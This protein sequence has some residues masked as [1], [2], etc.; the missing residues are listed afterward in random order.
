[1][2]NIHLR[3]TFYYKNN[4][5][6]PIRAGGVIIY[7]KNNNETEVLLIKKIKNDLENYEDIG[8]KTSYEDT[9]ILDTVSREVSE[10]TN[11]IINKNIIK[12]QINQ[13]KYKSIYNI[14]SKYILYFIKANSYERLLE[15]ENFGNL[16]IYDKIERTIV[17]VNVNEIINKEI[18]IHPRLILEDLINNIITL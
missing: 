6:K 9:S 12:K 5:N 8:G 4:K 10:E 2:D 3:P 17:W 7:R 14:K 15:S 1:M 16:E 11:Y 18:S 13:Y